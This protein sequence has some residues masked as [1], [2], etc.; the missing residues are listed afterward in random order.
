VNPQ[1]PEGLDALLRERAC[2][3]TPQ[4]SHLMAV[5][6][7][8]GGHPTAEELH[9]L[10]VGAMPA[11]SLR[12]VYDTLHL[13]VELGLVHRLDAGT[14]AIRYDTNL[15]LH[16]HVVCPVCHELSEAALDREQL[17]RALHQDDLDRVDVVVHRRCSRCATDAGGD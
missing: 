14:G 4:R 15:G 1:T 11:L 13:F 9:E 6:T 8:A 10:A 5:L 3:V 16:A 2:R 12:T 17:R 7:G